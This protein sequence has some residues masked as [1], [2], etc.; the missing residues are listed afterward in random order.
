MTGFECTTRKTLDDIFHG[1][2]PTGVVEGYL[3]ETV[4]PDGCHLGDHFQYRYRGVT[5]A[6]STVDVHD[7]LVGQRPNQCRES[8]PPDWVESDTCTVLADL[9]ARLRTTKVSAIFL[10]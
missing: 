5:L 2:L 9:T 1:E 8:R 6:E 7:A 4:R 3:N 10:F